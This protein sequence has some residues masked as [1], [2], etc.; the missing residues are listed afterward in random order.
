MHGRWLD[1]VAKAYFRSGEAFEKLND[2]LSARR[3][4]QEL[5]GREELAGFEE[6]LRAKERLQAL[7][8]PLPVETPTPEPAG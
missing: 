3:T 4:Y 5:S 8:G 6:S 1:W 2:S 7:G